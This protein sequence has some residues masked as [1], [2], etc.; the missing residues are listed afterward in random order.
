[1]KQLRLLVLTPEYRGYGGGIMT[2]YRALLP[3]LVRA[4]CSVTVIEGGAGSTA[5]HPNREVLE[6]VAVETLERSRLAR[7]RTRFSRLNAAPSVKTA[8]AASWAMWEQAGSG[9]SVD[10]VETTDF[11]LLFVAPALASSLPLIVQMHGSMGQIAI[12]DP[13][14]SQA[15]DGALALALESSLARRC[16]EVQT[17]S[18]ANASYWSSQIGRKVVYR[19]P[20]W[21]PVI[22]SA[23]AAEPGQRISVFG[24]V[25]R[26]KGPQVLCEALRIM[27]ASA[28]QVDWYGRDTSFESSGQACSEWLG[29]TYPD[30]WGSKVKWCAPIPPAQVATVQA[31]SLLNIVP[32]TWDVF[33]F[34]AAEAMASARPAICS[35][36]AGA[37]DLIEDGSTGFVYRNNDPVQLANAIE[38]ALAVGSAKLKKIGSSACKLVTEAL[39][40]K[41]IAAE[42]IHAY[43]AAITDPATE[44]STSPDWIQN[45]CSPAVPEKRTYAFLDQMPL[46]AIF[47]YS[48]ERTVRKVLTK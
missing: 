20:A 35:S 26:W 22:P 47:K 2:Y 24:R 34:T 13:L 10:V 43:R 41:E 45:L 1:M 7:W 28:P 3:A 6:G 21:A 37:S 14:E 38:R 9:Q 32:S 16:S 11:G 33:N 46:K 12:H 27:G 8:V 39:S 5:E 44:F 40:P 36:G 15:L 23:R 29:K 17:Y 48:A 31:G 30:V 42:R 25:Q 4:G 18:Q 19:R